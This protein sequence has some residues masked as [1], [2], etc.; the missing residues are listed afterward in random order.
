MPFASELEAAKARVACKKSLRW[1]LSETKGSPKEAYFP[2]FFN[3]VSQHR[4]AIQSICDYDYGDDETEG[5]IILANLLVKVILE[6][7]P[8]EPV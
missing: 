8:D 5:P 1:L 7:V 6:M 4:E 3:L 2:A